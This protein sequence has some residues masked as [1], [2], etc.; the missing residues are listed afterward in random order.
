MPVHR[1]FRPPPL[2]C[3]A[4]CD[5]FFVFDCGEL[6]A[7]GSVTGGQ[8][9]RVLE[10]DLSVRGVAFVAKQFREHDVNLE[11]GSGVGL[12]V[13]G[14]VVAEG[15]LGEARLAIDLGESRGSV[16]QRGVMYVIE[17]NR[18]AQGL[19][20]LVRLRAA[21]VEGA[22]VSPCIGPVRY[23]GGSVEFTLGRAV[24][25]LF[26]GGHGPHAVGVLRKLRLRAVGE[27]CGLLEATADDG[28]SV[29]VV[30]AEI[31]DG[32]AIERVEANRRLKGVANLKGEAQTCDGTGAVGLHAEGAA[33]PVLRGAVVGE[34]T[35]SSGTLRGGG[36]GHR[37]RVVGAAEQK[38][39][40]TVG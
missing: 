19:D 31:V 6:P 16:Y 38:V 37:L 10:F 26:L 29:D 34:G 11:G 2:Q 27:E 17:K 7:C 25:L 40:L 18:A 21:G 35:Q 5:G 12:R 1:R 8:L 4:L 23:G 14:K 3:L 39:R 9:E 32:V 28:G 20:G 30:F 15:A 24:V 33:S 36:R 22:E 13:R